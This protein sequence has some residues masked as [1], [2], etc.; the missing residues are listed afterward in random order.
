MGTTRKRDTRVSLKL[1]ASYL[2]SRN[3]ASRASTKLMGALL[4]AAACGERTSSIFI[5]PSWDREAAAIVLLLD[6]SGT[7]TTPPLVML[8]GAN[9]SFR[10]RVDGPYQIYVAT[11][12]MRDEL[13]RC[14]VVLGGSGEVL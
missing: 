9:A 5:A 4:F 8:P 2:R 13:E 11:Y 7:P 3:L 12:A 1:C 14:S 6:R 10:A